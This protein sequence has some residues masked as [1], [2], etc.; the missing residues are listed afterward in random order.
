MQAMARISQR[1]TLC[2][3]RSCSSDSVAS[4]CTITPDIT[5]PTG[6]ATVSP[7][8]CAVAPISTILPAKMLGSI[9]PCSTSA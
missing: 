3:S 9:L 7:S 1:E 2:R 5:P 8:S 4:A 6:V